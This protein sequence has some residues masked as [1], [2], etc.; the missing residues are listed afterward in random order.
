MLNPLVILCIGVAIVIGMIVVL[1]INAFVALISA[2]IVVSLL[3]PGEFSEKISRV[4]TEFGNTA[5]QI[6]I[7]IAMAAIIG[8]CLIES[9]AQIELFACSSAYWARNAVPSR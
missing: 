4:A 7:V 9:G 1:R 3:A 2:A 8:R 6:G 5:A